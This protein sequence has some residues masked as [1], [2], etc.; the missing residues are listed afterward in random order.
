MART[1]GRLSLALAGVLLITANASPAQGPKDAGFQP[2]GLKNLKHPDPN[3]R[4]RTAD[5]LAREGPKAKFAA[6]ELR[7]DPRIRDAYLGGAVAA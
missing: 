7:D 3:I 5:L 2:D 6:A 1:D 4:Y